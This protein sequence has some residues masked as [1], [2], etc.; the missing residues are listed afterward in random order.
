MTEFIICPK[1]NDGS[2]EV[3]VMDGARLDEK[4]LTHNHKHW[5][6]R[7][8]TCFLQLIITDSQIIPFQ[9]MLL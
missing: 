6:Y 4:Q 7:N 1:N 8:K 5:Y 2:M 3:N 9:E